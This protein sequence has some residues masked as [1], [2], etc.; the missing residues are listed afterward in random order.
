MDEREIIL[1]ENT[2]LYMTI[3]DEEVIDDIAEKIFTLE[4]EIIVSEEMENP[5]SFL[6]MIEDL[7]NMD[8]VAPFIF[9]IERDGEIIA[10][11]L[12]AEPKLCPYNLEAYEVHTLYVK[13]EFRGVYLGS[14]LMEA[15][16]DFI[17][18]EGERDAI[19]VKSSPQSNQFYLNLDFIEEIPY[20]L[21]KLIV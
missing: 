4:E 5:I 11:S 12:V 15:I 18:E 14:I 8:N 16:S 9:R 10:L 1:D 19:F 2:I 17:E 20:N 21:Y 7:T 13:K 3:A 6:A